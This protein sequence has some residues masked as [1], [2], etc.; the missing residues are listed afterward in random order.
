MTAYLVADIDVNDLEGYEGYKKGVP[1]TIAAHGG[2][3]LTRAGS[4][5]VLEGDWV[6]KRFVI[7]EFPSVAQLKSWYESP[8]YR[9]LR[10]IRLRTSKSSLVAVEGG[11]PP[12]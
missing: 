1:A 7:I 11:A 6:P 2:R 5:E 12:A 8:E 4:T 9:A 3:Y 10:D